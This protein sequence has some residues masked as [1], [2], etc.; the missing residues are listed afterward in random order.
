MVVAT[1]DSTFRFMI[2]A[3]EDAVRKV[4]MAPASCGLEKISANEQSHAGIG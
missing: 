1:S 4:R 2:D 3:L